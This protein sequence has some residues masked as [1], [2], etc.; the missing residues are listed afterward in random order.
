MECYRRRNQTIVQDIDRQLLKD[1][2]ENKISYQC[3]NGRNIAHI[4][5]FSITKNKQLVNIYVL[6]FH[7]DSASFQ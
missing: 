4:H 7:S 5:P 2:Y 3:V 6:C 1:I